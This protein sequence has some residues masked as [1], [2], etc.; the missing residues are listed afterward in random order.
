MSIAPRQFKIVTPAQK[1]QEARLRLLRQVAVCIG[2]LLLPVIACG[3]WMAFPRAASVKAPPN[4]PQASNLVRN[5]TAPTM[6]LFVEP[7]QADAAQNLDQLDQLVK[8]NRLAA[9]VV[10]EGNQPTA[11]LLAKARKLPNTTVVID[12]QNREAEQFQTASAGDCLLFDRHGKLHFH[13]E[14]AATRT[15]AVES[16]KLLLTGHPTSPVASVNRSAAAAQE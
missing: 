1:K 6:V 9:Y 13:G 12:Q 2:L 14:L 5:F 3:L 10:F 4:W 15:E 16:V 8:Q 11:S 7:E